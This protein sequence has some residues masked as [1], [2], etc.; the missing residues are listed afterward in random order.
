MIS[1]QNMKRFPCAFVLLAALL[2][3]ATYAMD[4]IAHRGASHAAPENTLAAFQLAWKEGADGI[5]GDFY[6]TKDRRIVCIHDKQTKRLAG[7]DLDVTQ[8]TLAELQALDVGV[9]KDPRF[10]GERIPT[11]EQVLA[12][13]PEGKRI[14]IEIKDS[15]RIV[16]HLQQVLEDAPVKSEQITIIAFSIDVIRMCKA[17]LPEIKASW[18]VSKKDLDRDTLSGIVQTAKGF[19]FKAIGLQSGAH[20]DEALVK[21]LHAAGLEL[22]TWTGNSGEDARRYHALGLKSVTTDKPGYIRTELK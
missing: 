10:A 3:S 9:W 19:D 1:Q 5:E 17:H 14:F 4:I 12:T 15:E 18:L 8:A 7:K 2:G 13:V 6:L 11:L 21:V 20:I 22:H 16:A